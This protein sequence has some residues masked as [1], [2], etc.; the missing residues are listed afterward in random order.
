MMKHKLFSTACSVF[1]GHSAY[2]DVLL[3]YGAYLY[4]SY[5]FNE[6]GF[7]FYRAGE[8]EQ[9]FDSFMKCDPPAWRDAFKIK[10]DE[11]MVEDTVQELDSKRI[12][13]DAAIICRDYLKDDTRSTQYWCRA[14]QWAEAIRVCP[15][16]KE[17]VVRDCL[18]QSAAAIADHLD[19]IMF[20]YNKQI[21]RLRIVKDEKMARLGKHTKGQY[22]FWH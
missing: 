3:T 10:I 8:M 15:L 14:G 4:E 5:D 12:F 7:V 11:E 16:D 22:Y 1:A 6:A 19:E 20:K 9:A 21:A 13:D 18:I 17:D 2:K